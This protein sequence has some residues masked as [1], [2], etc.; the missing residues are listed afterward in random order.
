[1]CL[2]NPF[3]KFV[4]VFF[5]AMFVFVYISDYKTWVPRFKIPHIKKKKHKLKIK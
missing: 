4:V 1:M 3:A 2:H 5:L